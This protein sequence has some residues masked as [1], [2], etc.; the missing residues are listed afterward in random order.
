M[1]RVKLSDFG[2]ANFLKRAKTLRVGA[3]EY[4]APKMFPREG[5][6]TPMPRPTTKC[7]VFSYGIVVVE[8]ITK[9]MPT[10]KNRHQ[11]FGEVERKWRL[12]YDL[13]SQCT[14]VNP[15]ARPTMADVLNI[16]NWIPTA[17]RQL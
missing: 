17:K 11:L 9:I 14:E 1:W 6:S 8:V 5:P 7:D 12:M 13:V 4:T 10:T 16:L 3:I 15:Q 2:S